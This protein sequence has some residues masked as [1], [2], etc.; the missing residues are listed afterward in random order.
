MSVLALLLAA[1]LPAAPVADRAQPISI[2]PGESVTLEFH[3]RKAIVV[4][5]KAAPP[6][7]PYERSVAADLGSRSASAGPGIQPAVPYSRDQIKEPPPVPTPDRV[8]LT[9]RIVPDSAGTEQ[10]S[11]LV[12]LNGY[13]QSFRYRVLMHRKGSVSPTDVCEVLS[14]V[15]MSEHWPYLI[16]QIDLVGEW[17]EPREAGQVR[18]E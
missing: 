15:P 16:D 9:F 5:R 10:Y 18:C 3:D 8:Q 4:E 11:L 6:L 14:N 12:V 1:L 7:S 13:A 2:R 17:L